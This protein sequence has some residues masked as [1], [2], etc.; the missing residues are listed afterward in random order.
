MYRDPGVAQEYSLPISR[1]T[2]NDV[3]WK[4]SGKAKIIG[5]EIVYKVKLSCPSSGEYKFG[6]I[7]AYI[8]GC[9]AWHVKNGSI[10]V[11]SNNTDEWLDVTRVDIST[12]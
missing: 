7:A 11:Y 10:P 3:S 5:S 2:L 4:A 6:E 9:I 1:S 12:I 8:G